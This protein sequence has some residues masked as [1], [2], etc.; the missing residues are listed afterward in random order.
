[1]RLVKVS[2]LGLGW[3]EIL[4]E[5]QIDSPLYRR[6]LLDYEA[7]TRNLALELYCIELGNQEI[8]G[9]CPIFRKKGA[10]ATGLNFA[11]IFKPGYGRKTFE[12][13]VKEIREKIGLDR[14]FVWRWCQWSL[15]KPNPKFD[16][17]VFLLNTS[18]SYKIYEAQIID[19]SADLLHA[20]NYSR[21]LRRSLQKQKNNKSLV[22]D[23]FDCNSPSHELISA[24][25]K[26]REIHELAAGYKTRSEASFFSMLNII[27]SGD[28]LLAHAKH[29]GEVVSALLTVHS[30]AT[31][32]G[33]SQAN[34]PEYWHLEP[35]H[36]LEASVINHYANS[37][38]SKYH[39]GCYPAGRNELDIDGKL[40][41]IKEFKTK[42]GPSLELELWSNYGK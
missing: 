37:G 11:P 16:F 20:E 14:D 19:L 5:F 27:E 21:S 29:E 40:Q 7:V 31:V 18:T 28:G 8:V 33:F 15:G 24:F 39:I 2:D 30:S 4:T 41:T 17:F 42:F 6:S 34:H 38:F 25:E 23:V 3:D 22:F 1:M 13:F 26:Y 10:E 32:V 35:R 9:L 36:F 12:A